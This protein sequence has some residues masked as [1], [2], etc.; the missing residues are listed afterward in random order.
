MQVNIKSILPLMALLMA[1]SVL[2][3]L[4]KEELGEE[5][6]DVYH[7]P[8][9]YE[10]GKRLY[11]RKKLAKLPKVIVSASRAEKMFMKFLPQ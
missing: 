9:D 6:Y 11:C 1:P 10:E 8:E 4:E 3:A 7:N 2:Y 5:C